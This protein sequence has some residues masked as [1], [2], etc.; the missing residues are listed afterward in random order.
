MNDTLRTF[1][2]RLRRAID[3]LSEDALRRPEREGKWSIVQVLAHLAQFELIWAVRVR[4]IVALDTPPLVPFDQE[5]WNAAV[6][7]G[8]P[9]AELLDQIAFLRAMNVA[10][11]ERLR[12]EEWDRAGIHAEYGHNTIHQLVERFEKHS[13]KHL[14]Q[15]ERIRNTGR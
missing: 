10:F 8:E 6:H 7:R 1:P 4:S 5:R 3:G 14:G 12:A 2:D 11:L 9:V 13:E 15:I